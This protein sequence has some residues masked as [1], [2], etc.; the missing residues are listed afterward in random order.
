MEFAVRLT[1]EAGVT[2]IPVS[3][4]FSSVLATTPMRQTSARLTCCAPLQVSAFYIS[5]DKPHHLV[6]FCFC[7]DDEKLQKACDQLAQY[8]GAR[9]S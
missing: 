2:V 5:K 1:K 7:K 8:F 4:Q 9:T 3:F 6:R